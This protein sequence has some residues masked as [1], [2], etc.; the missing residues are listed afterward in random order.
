MSERALCNAAAA[1]MFRS[2]LEDEEATFTRPEMGL[3]ILLVEDH[4]DTRHTLWRLLRHFNY[5]VV[6]A[7]D[8]QT[9]CSILDALPFDILLSDIRL[10]DG[11][12][13]DLVR[14]AKS[15]QP[16]VA[17]ALSALGTV[18]DEERGVSCGF[19]HYFVKP[20]DF[21]RLRVVLD[22]TTGRPRA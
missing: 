12:G 19:D 2:N 20:L 17:I 1:A 7:P 16:L 3:R 22:G 6:T 8:C 11:D 21:N 14:E 15:K 13:C 18:Q 4:N 10:P 5:D 9:A